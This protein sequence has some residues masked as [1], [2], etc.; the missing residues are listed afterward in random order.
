MCTGPCTGLISGSLWC[1]FLLFRDEGIKRVNCNQKWPSL[2][3]DD[4]LIPS[5]LVA[6]IAEWSKEYEHEARPPV[7]VAGI[8][9]VYS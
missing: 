4:G 3:L 6:F 8:L 5:M 2:L 9:L 7:P 1:S